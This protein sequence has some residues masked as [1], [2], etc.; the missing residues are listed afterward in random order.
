MKN[1]GNREADNH[2]DVATTGLEGFPPT[3]LTQVL[4]RVQDD[5]I[6]DE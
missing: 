3:F 5:S 2:S 6:G 1:A 4:Q